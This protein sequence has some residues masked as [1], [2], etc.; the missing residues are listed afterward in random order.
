MDKE[1]LTNYDNK[2][3]KEQICREI[4]KEF[5]N[6]TQRDISQISSIPLS[7]V[8]RYLSKEKEGEKK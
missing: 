3:Q 8:S 2:T 1:K 6:M 4:K 7:T 5:P